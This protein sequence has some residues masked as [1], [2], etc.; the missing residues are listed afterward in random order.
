MLISRFND[1]NLRVMASFH[2]LCLRDPLRS[3][4]LNVVQDFVLRF[5]LI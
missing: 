3:D 2:M 5:I 1:H 4:R